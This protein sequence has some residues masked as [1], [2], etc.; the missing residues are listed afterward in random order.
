MTTSKKRKSKGENI[1]LIAL[2][3]FR[4]SSREDWYLDS[5]C[6]RHMTRVNKYWVDI[7]SQFTSF[8]IFGDEAKGE[9]K[10]VGKLACTELPRLDDV[11]LVK[12]LTI[13]M[14]S[15]SQLYDQGLKFNFTK[16]EFFVTNE[17]NDI[18]IRGVRSKDNFY[19]WVPQKITYSSTCLIT[20]ED[21]VKLWHQKLGHLISKV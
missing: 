4:A 13:N 11:V 9:I 8:V 16:L 15:I 21:G 14:I 7:R 12:G 1:N 17:K 2:T 19:L 10:R 6:S 18:M 20:K 5:G 3:S